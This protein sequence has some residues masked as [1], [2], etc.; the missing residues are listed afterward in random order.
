MRFWPA[1]ETLD[2][3]RLFKDGKIYRR[4]VEG[5]QRVFGATM[6]FYEP[7]VTNFPISAPLQNPDKS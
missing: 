1:S 4:L 3:F 5:F 6:F 7:V 2:F